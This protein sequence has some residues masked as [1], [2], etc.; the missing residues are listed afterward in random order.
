MTYARSSSAGS[1]IGIASGRAANQLEL[2]DRDERR[3]EAGSV[4]SRHADDRSAAPE[5]SRM[6]RTRAAGYAGIDAARTRP[7]P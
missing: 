1:S 5:S 6:W 3:A 7:E 2:F 4:A